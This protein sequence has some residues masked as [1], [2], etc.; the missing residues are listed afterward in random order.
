MLHKRSF[1]HRVMQSLESYLRGGAN[2]HIEERSRHWTDIDAMS[3]LGPFLS[4]AASA[5]NLRN[6]SAFDHGGILGFG[7]EQTYA[8]DTM[9]GD[10]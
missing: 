2:S 8:V 9:R 4:M 3:G 1:L 5:S 10:R 7:D 6:P